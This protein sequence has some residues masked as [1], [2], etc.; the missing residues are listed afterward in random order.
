MEKRAYDMIHNNYDDL[1]R[2][3][4]GKIAKYKVVPMPGTTGIFSFDVETGVT[5]GNGQDR[6]IWGLGLQ[7][8][9]NFDRALQAVHKDYQQLFHDMSLG[10]IGKE[11]NVEFELLLKNG[12]RTL[13]KYDFVG[14][15]EDNEITNTP[16][17][18]IGSTTLL[19][20]VA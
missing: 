13:E 1:Y 2:S 9:Y 17:K 10:Q 3:D 15:K 12:N 16:L 6:L 14:H 19:K 20:K 7:E 11:K 8:E 5:N 4:C 18:I